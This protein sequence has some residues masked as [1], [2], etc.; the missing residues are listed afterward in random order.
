[1]GP[2][3]QDSARNRAALPVGT[4]RII[5]F[6]V[7]AQ[8]TRDP[9]FRV[10][11]CLLMIPSEA[12]RSGGVRRSLRH[13]EPLDGAELQMVVECLGR[14]EGACVLVAAEPDVADAA[15]A[16]KSLVGRR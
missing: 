3:L 2:E 5:R 14:A 16:D 4:K 6:A 1:M 15:G 8:K 9:A 12:A 13:G 11:L 7:R 10:S